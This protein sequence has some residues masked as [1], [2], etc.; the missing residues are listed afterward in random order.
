[1]M[2]QTLQEH[3][4]AAMLQGAGHSQRSKLKVPAEQHSAVPFFRGSGGLRLEIVSS[5]CVGKD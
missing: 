1:M 4:S 5:W 2:A 3:T